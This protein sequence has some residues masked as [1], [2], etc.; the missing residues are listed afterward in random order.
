MLIF[1]PSS[2]WIPPAVLPLI[3]D[4][5]TADS[6]APR[7]L[8]PNIRDIVPAVKVLATRLAEPLLPP[9]TEEEKTK[10]A[11]E[12][13]VGSALRLGKGLMKVKDLPA[14]AGELAFA[15][16]TDT[17]YMGAAFELPAATISMSSLHLGL[18]HLHKHPPAFPY[19]LPSLGFL[20]L[21]GA[22][23]VLIQGRPAAH[24][25]DLGLAITCGA[26]TPLFQVTTGSSKV[27]FGSHRAAR[28]L[29]LTTFCKPSTKAPSLFSTVTEIAKP[30]GAI[31]SAL[32]AA[33]QAPQPGP[34]HSPAM[35]ESLAAEASGLA[36]AA[37][38]KTQDALIGAATKALSKT[39][40]L[41]AAVGPV[42]P[43]ALSVLG[44]SV[45]IGGFPMLPS[46]KLLSGLKKV[47][48]E[49]Q[50]LPH[51][52]HV[53][54]VWCFSPAQ[55]RINALARH[56]RHYTGHPVD[57]VTGNLVFD[58]IDLDLPGSPPLR[59]AR[60]YSSAWSD[61]DSPLGRGWSHSL[62]EALWHEPRHLVYRSEDGRELELPHTDEPELYIPLHRLTLRRIAPHHYQIEDPDG[63]RRD[64][65]PIAGDPHPGIAR[66]ILR[67][68][69]LGHTVS[70]RYDT[71]ARLVS[72]HADGDRSL[73]LHYGDTHHITRI[74]LPDPDGDGHLP[75]LR[76]VHDGDDLVE[77]HD[78]LGQVTR[79]RHDRHRI[80]EETFHDGL[81]FHFQYDGDTSDAACTRTWGDGGLLD[82]RLIYDRARRTTLV[83]NACNETTTYR[84]DP[85]G[86]VTEI[87]DPRGAVTRFEYDAH[88]QRTAT[89]DALGHITRHEYDARGNLTR[90]TNPDGATIVTEYHPIFG[91]PVVRSEP[92]GAVSRW[93]YDPL[94]R[95]VRHTDP[96]GRSTVHQYALSP[97]SHHIEAIVH[98]DG[99]SELHTHDA[100]GRLLRTRPPDGTCTLYKY[101]RRGRL[102]QRIDDRGRSETRDYDLLGR[103]TRHTLPGGE[104]RLYTHDARG[105]IIRACDDRTDLRCSYSGLGWLATCGDANSPPVTLERDLE[106]RIRRVAGRAGTLLAIE[107]DAA[108]HV[109]STRDALGI[110]R[111]YTRDLRGHIVAIRRPGGKLTRYDRDITGRITEIHHGDGTH[112]SYTYRADAALQTATRRHPDGQISTT[113]RDLDAL[114]RLT[115]EHQDDHAVAL[116]YDL[117]DRP[118]R[119][120]SSLGADLRFHHDD[121]G[122]TRVEL[123]HE[124]WALTFE[125]DRDG[126]EQ[127]RHLPGEIVGWWQYDHLGRPAEHGVVAS[128]PPQ[129]FRQ[130]RY[131]WADHR[132]QRIEETTRRRTIYTPTTPIAALHHDAEGRRTTTHLRDGTAWSY[133]WNDAGELV[134]ATTNGITLSYRHDALGRRITR[135]RNG[136][137]TRWQWHGNVPLH[138]WQ[139]GHDPTTWV[140]IPNSF[141]PLARLTRTTRHAF[142]SD[143]LGT[144]LAAFDY[145]G[146][147]A[148]SGEFDEHGQPRTVRGDPTVCPFRFP[149]QLSD[150]DTGLAHNRFREYDPTTRRYL[151]PDPLGLLGGLDPHA[152]VADPQTQTDVFGLTSDRPTSVAAYIA[153]E[154]AQD[155]L[156]LD[157]TPAL[158][159]VVRSLGLPTDVLTIAHDVLH[160][161]HRST[162]P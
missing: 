84:A 85:R 46:D 94:G 30:V 127:T 60:S 137:E 96:L 25:G 152:Y 70:L 15:L 76:Y 7:G 66:L 116:E 100:A 82:H 126:H 22:S 95:V 122:L 103:L 42:F 51:A 40:G 50:F 33:V 88:L 101:D 115:R 106:G 48:T 114:G 59:F 53:A 32:N 43:G 138:S 37:A 158:M 92:H 140:F 54:G 136:L 61:R 104:T 78:A 68:D 111:R 18:P 49:K 117:H 87:V 110:E 133:T 90:A 71:R 47:L 67:R 99:R 4:D 2:A 156:P 143:H 41:D 162:C 5:L 102:R 123:P 159:D 142:V 20:F 13:A 128:R 154:L 35:A 105:R 52:A 145:A 17:R 107:R 34:Q 150:P 83:I 16:A 86:L 38:V 129:I 80:I 10:R 11:H 161:P 135:V 8:T 14:Q 64:F 157:L 26:F 125:R 55:R 75:H 89:T 9:T 91:L 134:G 23:S 112:D 44:T 144:P 160:T 139:L 58:A 119:L 146:Q 57:V 151:S 72:V 74:D 108:G 98:P 3:P 6:V 79:Y 149:G 36:L 97:E 155:L 132:L 24:T 29:D 28:S 73:R 62:D 81:S 124:P 19:P 12:S 65:A 69:R 56:L 120:R 147:L 121:R 77:I 1:D 93:S 118:I 131:T 63:L 45:L 21:G 148:W 39:L 27:F 153:H 113:R 109:R 130:R 141:T 31:A